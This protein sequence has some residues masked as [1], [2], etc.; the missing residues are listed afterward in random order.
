MLN[1]F[2]F[3]KIYQ[4]NPSHLSKWDYKVLFNVIFNVSEFN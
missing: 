4:Q 3:S 1:R 2:L